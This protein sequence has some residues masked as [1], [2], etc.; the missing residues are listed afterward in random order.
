MKG[1]SIRKENFLGEKKIKEQRQE[2]RSGGFGSRLG[3]S[4]RGDL[5]S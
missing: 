5:A 1:V 3:E 2:G 4:G